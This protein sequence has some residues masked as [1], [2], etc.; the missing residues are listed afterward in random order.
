MQQQ[1]TGPSRSQ[2]CGSAGSQARVTG[3]HADDISITDH[4]LLQ[5]LTHQGDRSES[6]QWLPQE[7]SC[8]ERHS[9]P[10][11]LTQKVGALLEAPK[12]SRQRAVR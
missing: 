11:K 9:L 7:S 2:S 1:S 4:A 8:D 6:R 3:Q 12:A 10:P 5:T